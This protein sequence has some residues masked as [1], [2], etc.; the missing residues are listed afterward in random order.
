M[1]FHF[2]QC[3]YRNIQSNGLQRRYE[4]DADFALQMRHLPSLAFVPVEDVVVAFEDLL[5]RIDFPLGSQPVLDY[6]EDTWIG[7]PTRGNKR[8]PPRT[9]HS[10]WSC[11]DNVNDDL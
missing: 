1:F 11:Y 8:R 3:I 4:N 9:P 2:C 7:R 5:S 10:L 6:F